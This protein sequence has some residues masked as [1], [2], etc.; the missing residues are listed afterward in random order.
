MKH[1]LP[2][3]PAEAVAEYWQLVRAALVA[4]GLSKK[5]A[6]TTAKAY[7]AW[8]KPAGWTIYND[9]PEDSAEAAKDYAAWMREEQAKPSNGTVKKRAKQPA[10]V[11]DELATKEEILQL[12]RWAQVAFAARCARRVEPLFLNNWPDAPLKHVEAVSHAVAAVEQFAGQLNGI[13]DD[14][15]MKAVYDAREAAG[16]PQ[17]DG[18]QVH[19]RAT[20]VAHATYYACVV[21]SHQ[22]G[23]RYAPTPAEGSWVFPDAPVWIRRDLA[24]LLTEV[25]QGNWTDDL[26]LIH[27]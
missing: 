14:R 11:A 24:T 16:Q 8:M 10:K 22:H 23:E 9:D 12:P 5:D 15:I 3:L 7:R 17:A 18:I 13:F 19:M 21:A 27:I 26:S 2:E 25:Q 20:G 1:R 4:G 6:A